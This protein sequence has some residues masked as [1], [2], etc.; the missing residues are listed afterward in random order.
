MFTGRVELN[1]NKKFSF[2]T[3][4]LII[5]EFK[6]R[7]NLKITDIAGD[8]TELTYVFNDP[9]NRAVIYLKFDPRYVLNMSMEVSGSIELFTK[10][11]KEITHIVNEY[12]KSEES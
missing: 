3:M 10:Y 12:K 2:D 5:G 6:Y 11:Y 4:Y 9:I 1:H 8:G 7:M